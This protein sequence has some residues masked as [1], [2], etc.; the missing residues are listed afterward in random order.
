[1]LNRDE[2]RKVL[3]LIS[4]YDV[5]TT[6]DVRDGKLF[7]STPNGLTE[8]ARELIRNHRDELITLLTCPPDIEG[9]CIRGHAITWVCSEQGVWICSCYYDNIPEPEQA[10]FEPGQEEPEQ[11]RTEPRKVNLTWD[12]QLVSKWNGKVKN[13][14]AS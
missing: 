2:T 1:M 14:I 12:T 13:R 7:V 3:N 5:F 9:D 11:A 4:S 10:P 6:Y 8:Q